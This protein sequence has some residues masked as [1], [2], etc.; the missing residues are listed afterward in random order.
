MAD[1]S[2]TPSDSLKDGGPPTKRHKPNN[3]TDDKKGKLSIHF[4]VKIEK[5]FQQ[6][7]KKLFFLKLG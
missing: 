6:K 7:F 3:G 5:K 4:F 1:Q 2:L